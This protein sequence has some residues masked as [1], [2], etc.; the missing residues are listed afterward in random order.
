METGGNLIFGYQQYMHNTLNSAAAGPTDPWKGLVCAL[1]SRLHSTWLGWML[2]VLGLGLTLDSSSASAAELP[3]LQVTLAWDPNPEN[4]LQT[5]VI[6]YGLRPG[7]YFHHE[8]VGL[9]TMATIRLPLPRLTYYIA[10]TAR[11]T[12]GLESEYSS[13]LMVQTPAGDLP[14]KEILRT[15]QHHEDQ[16]LVLDFGDVAWNPSA[17]WTTS[18]P[19]S[20]GTIAL[21]DSTLIYIPN[22]NKWGK[23]NFEI[24]GNLGTPEPVRWV[25]HV[26]VLPANDP[27]LALDQVVSADVTLP[28]DILLMGEDLDNDP[29]TFRIVGQPTQGTLTGTPPQVVYTP[30]SD[31][32]GF[33]S[34]SY[35]VSDGT[36]SSNVAVV[37]LELV[38]GSSLPFI[39]DQV[40]EVSEDQSFTFQLAL[41]DRPDLF[42]RVIKQPSFGTILGAPPILTYRP[43]SNYFGGDSITVEVRDPSGLTS[44]AVI[45]FDVIPVND[46]PVAQPSTVETPAGT[47]VELTLSADDV[48]NDDLLFEIINQPSRGTITGEPPRLFYL[49][50]PGESGV[51]SLTFRAYDGDAFSAPTVISINVKPATPP[52]TVRALLDPAGN[53]VLRW[54]STPGQRFRVLSREQLTQSEWLPASDPIVATSITVRWNGA[55][56]PG[57]TALFYAVEVL[58]P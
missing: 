26:D 5:Y 49:P 4:D 1:R 55:A 14:F 24:V 11:D 16:V 30:R 15:N 9:V 35:Q 12:E 45:D 54:N 2:A 40:F 37:T 47:P 23:D 53:V 34:F 52:L 19:P 29:I 13:E 41:L 48:D 44:T 42:T 46:L 21:R 20:F 33:D 57:T 31:A 50:N 36:D 8:A 22:P 27:P 10:V 51:D 6:H 58:S 3:S 25:W 28:V 56:L 39:Q 43:S 38:P 7:D 17:E 32:K 18:Q